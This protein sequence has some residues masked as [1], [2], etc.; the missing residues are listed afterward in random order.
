MILFVDPQWQRR[1]VAR[2]LIGDAVQPVRESGRQRLWVTGN[3]NAVAF[4]AAVGFLG[5][6]RVAT[7][8]GPGLRLH[9]DCRLT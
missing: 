4:Y 2:R 8:L 3:P 7:K 9:L 1:G 5:S 6:E